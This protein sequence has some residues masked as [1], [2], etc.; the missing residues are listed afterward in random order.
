MHF[1]FFK[2]MLGNHVA[3]YRRKVTQNRKVKF[4]CNFFEVVLFLNLSVIFKRKFWHF[5]EMYLAFTKHI[6]L[7]NL[8]KTWRKFFSFSQIG[9]LHK[10]QTLEFHPSL[11]KNGIAIVILS[12]QWSHCVLKYTKMTLW[13]LVHLLASE[14]LKQQYPRAPLSC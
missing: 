12:T 7:Q 6:H 4:S 9:L 1:S 2:C 11:I 14:E 13:S 5:K 3:N 8:Q 10:F